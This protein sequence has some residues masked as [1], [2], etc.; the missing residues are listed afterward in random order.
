MAVAQPLDDSPESVILEAML[1]AMAEY[2]SRN[3]GREVMKGMRETAY[4]A[5]HTG[6]RPPLGYDVDPQ[7]KKYVFNRAASANFGKRNNHANKPDNEIIRI[8][9][10]IPAIMSYDVWK[11]VQEIMAGRKRAPQHRKS[12]DSL[13]I[14]TGKVGRILGNPQST[15]SISDTLRQHHSIQD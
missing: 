2:Y 3:L 15:S 10:G 4:Q 9:G 5:K 1:E 11:K 13:Y 6:G 12:A 14:L 7:T 8:P